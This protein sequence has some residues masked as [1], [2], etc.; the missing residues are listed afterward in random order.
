MLKKKITLLTMA[1]SLL[2][3]GVSH[4][5]SQSEYAL[6]RKPIFKNP[7]IWKMTR[8][9]TNTY[10]DIDL[11]SSPQSAAQ[12]YIMS[13]WH[14]LYSAASFSVDRAWDRIIY[15]ECLDN[16]I[17]AYGSY[18]TGT[19][20]FWWPRSISAIAPFNDSLY[21]YY[22]YIYVTDT[23][24][25]RIVRLK[26]DWGN[27]VMWCYPPI[28]GG[29]LN[30]P[31]NHDLNNNGTF[32][33]VSDDYLWIINV[34]DSRP[35]QIKRFSVDGA[36]LSTFGNF[37]CDGEVGD[38]C[39]LT[40][41]V[42]GR[43]AFLSPP[44]DP[45]ANTNDFYVA[46]AGNNRIV[47]LAKDSEGET[48]SWYKEVPTSS[49]IVD[50]EV[51]N[52]GQLWA[53]DK[54]SGTITK[55]T[56]DLFPLCT[57]GSEGTGDNQFWHPLSISNTGGYLACGNMYVVEEWTDSSGG[58]YFSIGTDIVDFEVTSSPDRDIHYLD[59]VLIDPSDVSVKIYNAS[60]QLVKTLFDGGQFSGPCSFV[61]DGTN[62]SGEQ[63]PPGTYRVVI[64]DSSIYGDY[65]T[66]EPT[67]VVTKDWWVYHLTEPPSCCQHRGDVNG[68]GRVNIA[69]LDWLVDL[70]FRGGPPPPCEDEADV[71]D[72]GE[73][74]VGD[75]TYL[76]NY[77]FKGGPQPPP[78]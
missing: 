48:I 49:S 39:H 34:T 50:L 54:E 17:R 3:N 6:I 62:D 41:I 25:N 1:T 40:A 2:L 77:L 59:Y 5:Q 76:I 42:S 36:L 11:F 74:N 45:Y 71:D 4:C 78:C 15:L 72:S 63:V 26:Y 28:D 55:Y 13:P 44:Y 57:F 56:Y 31:F 68:N 37:G 75:L 70:L 18:G 22:Y 35:S 32:L 69:D 66:G 33:P 30:R 52:F 19:C 24:N 10:W 27:Q 61:W 64:V 38:F 8:N 58:Q 7:L 53:V 51:D 9:V 73:I 23:E 47:W 43:S 67:N 29:G 21:S 14:E 16:W 46:D 20:Q 12:S 60:D 65:T